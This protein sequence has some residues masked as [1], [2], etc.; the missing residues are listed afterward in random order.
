MLSGAQDISG[1][2]NPSPASSRRSNFF[3]QRFVQ[4]HRCEL[5][6]ELTLLI[7][8]VINSDSGS[9]VIFAGGL[10]HVRDCFP[11]KFAREAST[12]FANIAALGPTF[13]WALICRVFI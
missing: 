4:I 13:C 10:V 3:R 12:G 7:D 2:Q 8:D 9:L 11:E 1:D 5:T 6:D